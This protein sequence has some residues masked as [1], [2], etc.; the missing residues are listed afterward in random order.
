MKKLIVLVVV[1]LVLI[2]IGLTGCFGNNS[3]NGN[4]D[5][6]FIGDWDDDGHI[7]RISSSGTVL[8]KYSYETD[9]EFEKFGTIDSITDDEIC[10]TDL[11][12]VSNCFFYKIYYDNTEITIFNFDDGDNLYLT[13]ISITPEPIN[14]EE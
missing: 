14:G 6:R 10:A 8:I 3:G 12:G 4:I 13:K 7:Y 1:T 11:S 5:S 2:I 9:S